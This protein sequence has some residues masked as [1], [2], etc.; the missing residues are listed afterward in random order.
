MRRGANDLPAF[1]E[2]V[3]G[4]DNREE[5]EQYQKWLHQH[6]HCTSPRLPGIDGPKI[7]QI[8]DEKNP[9]LYYIDYSKDKPKE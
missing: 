8:A 6:P 7:N 3:W 2:R 9:K 4:P 1:D 5:L